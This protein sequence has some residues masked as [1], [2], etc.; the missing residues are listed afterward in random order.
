MK[1]IIV[2]LKKNPVPSIIVACLVLLVLVPLCISVIIMPDVGSGSDDGW[3]GFFGGYLGAIIGLFGAMIIIYIQLESDEISRKEEKVD[4][5]FFNL[6]NL[7]NEI[8]KE[9]EQNKNENLF[10]NLYSELKEVIGQFKKDTKIECIKK[11]FYSNRD[12]IGSFFDKTLNE[13]SKSFESVSLINAPQLSG[14]E[15]NDL[16]EVE[17]SGSL[18]RINELEPAFVDVLLTLNLLGVNSFYESTIDENILNKISIIKS[19]DKQYFNVE[20]TN[21]LFK[22]IEDY[23]NQVNINTT[24]WI[25]NHKNEI[26]EGVFKNYYDRMGKYFR[27]FHRVIKYINSN[28]SDQEL[29]NN[30][31]GFIRAML[32]EREI[33]LI[34]YNS[35]FTQRGEGLGDELKQTQFF[36]DSNDLNL[37]KGYLQHFTKELLFWEEDDVNKMLSFLEDN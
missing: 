34:Y 30:Y 28:V 35:F 36:G 4:N 9:V 2:K 32:N 10:E 14:I 22:I 17:I 29:K 26:I 21:E 33:V 16:G 12:Y 20:T 25:A 18:T 31:I 27:I 19:L 8:K 23:D 5:T 3:L 1:K 37:A 6:L 15:N 13:M 11:Y 7:H 24:K